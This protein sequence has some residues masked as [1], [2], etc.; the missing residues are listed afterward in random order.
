MPW[1][2]KNLATVQKWVEE[3]KGG[4]SP[5]LYCGGA[6]GSGKTHLCTAA[7]GVLLNSGKAVRYMLWSDEARMLKAL[8]NDEDEYYR[9]IE[10]LKT[11][12]VLYIDDLFKVQ[13]GDQQGRIT[14]ADIRLAFELI[15]ARY[16][17][18]RITIISCEWLMDELLGLDEG[19][20][21]RIYERSRGYRVQIAREAGRN[22]RLAM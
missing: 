17:N 2:Q 7:C 13:R 5:W 22:M 12:D 16:R 9:K 19:V 21:S 11:C 18:D 1:Q 15:D 10:P 14:P 3:V 4:G 6:V 20:S 8:V